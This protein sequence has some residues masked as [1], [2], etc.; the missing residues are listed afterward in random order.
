MLKCSQNFAFKIFKMLKSVKIL[1]YFRILVMHNLKVRI[2]AFQNIKFSQNV[3]IRI[4]PFTHH[5]VSTNLEFR[6]WLSKILN[7]AKILN[8]GVWPII[9]FKCSQ[10][11]QIRIS[12]MFKLVKLLNSTF[13]FFNILSSVKLLNLGFWP[14]TIS[15]S[16]LLLSRLQ[17]SNILNSKLP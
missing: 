6:I 8:S 7:L 10:K 12:K 4:L 17:L 16:G 1:N 11:L 9:I 5:E 3:E 2:F 15:K 13:W 14:P